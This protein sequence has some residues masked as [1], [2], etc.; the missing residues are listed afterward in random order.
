LAFF[1]TK[2]QE[3]AI[4]RLEAQKSEL[5]LQNEKARLNI[6][7][8]KFQ[9]EMTSLKSL[10]RQNEKILQAEL[11]L[12]KM[13]EEG[14]KIANINLLELQDIK[15]KVIETKERLIQIKTALDQNAIYANYMQGN[16]NE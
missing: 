9:K 5:L 8:I 1:N 13:F 7:T 10:K 16:Y 12:L 6:E 3:K 14:Y 15:N 2:S 11:E 4:S